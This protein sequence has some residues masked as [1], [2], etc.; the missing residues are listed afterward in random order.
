MIHPDARTVAMFDAS[1]DPSPDDE[2]CL[3]DASPANPRRPLDWRWTLAGYLARSDSRS[4]RPWIDVPVRRA[5]R[6]LQQAGFPGRRGRLRPDTALLDALAL[7]S[8]PDSPVRT[9]VEVLLLAGEGDEAIAARVGLDA[10][11]VAAYHDLL[12]DV[13]PLLGHPDAVLA[14]V[15]G[16]R[17]YIEPLDSGQ[18]VWLLAYRGGPL[19]A[20]PLV[21]AVVLPRPGGLVDRDDVAEWFGMFLLAGSLPADGRSIPSL[22]ALYD[23]ACQLLP[24]TGSQTVAGVSGPIVNG[25]VP[26]HERLEGH[27]LMRANDS[28]GPISG[29]TLRASDTLEGVEDDPATVATGPMGLFE[30]LAR[31]GRAV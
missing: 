30:D 9:A 24:G 27:D 11:S 1:H 25:D 12:F 19:I 17:I 14:R 23:Q 8:G 22:L 3:L 21:D 31:L 13:R 18:A 5:V 15:F 28:I 4:R 7:R 20:G 2:Y 6:H 10:D 16:E 29:P 26:G